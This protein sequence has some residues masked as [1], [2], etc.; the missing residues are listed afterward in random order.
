VEA[1][2]LKE[3]MNRPREQGTR[4]AFLKSTGAIAA[5]RWSKSAWQ[6]TTA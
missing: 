5:A 4:R 1:T 2:T 6:F 3:K